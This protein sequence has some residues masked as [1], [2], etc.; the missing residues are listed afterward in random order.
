MTFTTAMTLDFDGQQ[1]EVD[2][3]ALR[4]GE[5]HDLAI[6][7]EIPVVLL[8]SNELMFDHLLSATW[9][10]LGGD[11]AKFATYDHTN[12]MRRIADATQQIYLELPSFSAWERSQ[13][14][15]KMTRPKQGRQ[16]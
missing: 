8:T 15:K 11:C 13:L 9:K 6:A 7:P 1:V 5:R 3:F 10:D 12:N 16:S 14:E 4:R 2:F